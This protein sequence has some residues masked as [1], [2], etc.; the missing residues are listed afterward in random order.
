MEGAKEEK[1]KEKIGQKEINQ[2]YLKPQVGINKEVWV[3]NGWW[4][5]R[6]H[7]SKWNLTESWQLQDSESK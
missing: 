4:T 7:E 3:H 5:K 2:T 6:C 1:V